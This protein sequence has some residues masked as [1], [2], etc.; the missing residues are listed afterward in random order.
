VR[1]QKKKSSNKMWQKNSRGC[2]CENR[3]HT[4]AS[5][6][7]SNEF[8]IKILRIDASEK[9]S[10][11]W[12][13]GGW[14]RCVETNISNVTV[15][16]RAQKWITKNIN[17]NQQGKFYSWLG[18]EQFGTGNKNWFRLRIGLSS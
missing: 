9:G 14:T 16:D 10:D 13:D 5:S 18:L 12:A 17:Y 3:E 11:L 4:F 6:A 8:R 1:K 2:I 15:R 7:L